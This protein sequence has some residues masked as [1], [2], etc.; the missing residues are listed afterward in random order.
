MASTSTLATIDDVDV[1]RGCVSW[2]VVVQTVLGS[3]L[4]V[5]EAFGRISCSTWPHRR[6]SH[7]DTWILP[8]PL[9]LS[10]LVLVYGLWSTAYGFFGTRALLGSTVDTCSTGGLGRI[11][12]LRCGELGLN[13]SRCFWLQFLQRGSHVGIWTSFLQVL[14]F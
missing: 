8:S 1:V 13:G 6:C 3:R 12:F 2:C 4:S 5:M 10:V 7:L 14:H 11:F 9:Y